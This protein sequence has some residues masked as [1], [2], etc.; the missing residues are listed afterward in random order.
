MLRAG[1]IR[2]GSEAVIVGA[3]RAACCVAFACDDGRDPS[4]MWPYPLLVWPNLACRDDVGCASPGLWPWPSLGSAQSGSL[5]RLLTLRGSM[6]LL[7]GLALAREDVDVLGAVS[8]VDA[9]LCEIAYKDALFGAAAPVAL[10][11]EIVG[12]VPV[13]SAGVLVPDLKNHSSRVCV[14][15][16]ADHLCSPVGSMHYPGTWNLPAAIACAFC[17]QS[18]LAAMLAACFYVPGLLFKGMKKDRCTKRKI[19]SSFLPRRDLLQASCLIRVEGPSALASAELEEG[20]E[21]FN[22]IIPWND[23]SDAVVT[24]SLEYH[25]CIITA[26]DVVPAFIVFELI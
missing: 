13:P 22:N 23:V 9:A 1:E 20:H 15:L 24:E 21:S 16:S 11:G 19:S 6:A 2:D 14:S 25:L 12:V 26:F 5:R 10:D 4:G 17:F 3:H 18:L 7:K 8:K